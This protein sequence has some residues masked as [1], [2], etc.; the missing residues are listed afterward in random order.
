MHDQVAQFE[1]LPPCAPCKFHTIELG[2]QVHSCDVTLLLLLRGC[3]G[4]G[5]P[6]LERPEGLALP[7]RPPPGRCLFAAAAAPLA[8]GLNHRALHIHSLAFLVTAIVLPAPRIHI[9][10]CR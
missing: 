1:S 3:L 6:G 5:F 10:P 7:P 9:F 4:R 2:I 8:R